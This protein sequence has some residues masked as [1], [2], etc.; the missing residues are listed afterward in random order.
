[1]PPPCRASAHLPPTFSPHIQA[2]WARLHQKYFCIRQSCAAIWVCG[3]MCDGMQPLNR[4]KEK[5]DALIWMWKCLQ[6]LLQGRWA[7][8]TSQ[9]PFSL[10]PTS[11]SNFT[12][13][14]RALSQRW[15]HIPALCWML[16]TTKI[17][18][19][20]LFRSNLLQS[21]FSTTFSSFITTF[22][23]IAGYIIKIFFS[24]RWM[25]EMWVLY[26]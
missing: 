12:T 4:W 2:H 8:P 7:L 9:P 23:Y 18:F 1:M 19:V 25:L 5:Y 20:M 10:R 24:A 26:W 16:T 11:Y 13:N 6:Y 17:H 14:V 21:C 3:S 15:K 22:R